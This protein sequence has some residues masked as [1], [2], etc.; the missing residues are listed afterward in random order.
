MGTEGW[1]KG[2]ILLRLAWGDPVLCSPWMGYSPG[3]ALLGVFR[4]PLTSSSKLQLDKCIWAATGKMD[5]R[6]VDAVGLV[7][8]PHGGLREGLGGELHE[9]PEGRPVVSPV[10]YCS[11]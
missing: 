7:W 3:H 8:A 11:V 5:R 1:L 4:L 2:P 9:R 10:V 6:G